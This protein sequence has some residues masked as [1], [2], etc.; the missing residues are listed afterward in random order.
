MSGVGSSVGCAED[1]DK[2]GEP[3]MEGVGADA[4]RWGVGGICA[5]MQIGHGCSCRCKS[6]TQS[7][8]KTCKHGRAVK[9]SAVPTGLSHKRQIFALR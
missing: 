2:I 4:I 6:A 5:G 9:A 7:A 3:G 1:S 8:W